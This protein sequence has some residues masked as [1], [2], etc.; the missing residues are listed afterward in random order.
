MLR[1]GHPPLAAHRRL[2]PASAGGI[3]LAHAGR[4]PCVVDDATLDRL[5]DLKGLKTVDLE[6]ATV[7]DAGIARLKAA[8]PG[9]QTMGEMNAANARTRA[10]NRARAASAASSK[11]TGTQP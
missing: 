6:K 10:A 2:L 8:L 5:G 7:T 9:L 3:R 11:S 4:D 1:R